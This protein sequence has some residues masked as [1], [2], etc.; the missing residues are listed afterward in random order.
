MNVD[1]VA[2]SAKHQMSICV[3]VTL[4]ILTIYMEMTM[5]K[6]IGRDYR[7]VVDEVEELIVNAISESDEKLAKIASIVGLEVKP[8]GRGLYE[9]R[10][11][12]SS[13]REF[14]EKVYE[15]A[16]GDDAINRDF[17][18]GEVLEELRDNSDRAWGISKDGQ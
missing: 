1:I 8:I 13:E 14:I 6:I 7:D 18:Y 15:I 5:S 3:M 4:A 10:K 2:A 12:V 11:M 16:F 9:V 17:T